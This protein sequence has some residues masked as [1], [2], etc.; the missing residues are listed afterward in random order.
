MA[1]PIYGQNKQ[2]DKFGQ[3]NL[4]NEY[5][6]NKLAYNSWNWNDLN[7]RLAADVT[8]A[9][10]RAGITLV[11]GDIC[12]CLVDGGTGASAITLPS[13][14]KGSLTVFRFSAQADGGQNIVFSCG[15]GDTFEAG[16]I[17]VGVT[18]LGD[19]LMVA[20]RPAYVETWTQTVAVGGGAIVTVAGAHNTLTIA[21]TATDN[22]TAI[23][24]E[25]AFFCN[26]DNKWRFGFLGSELGSGAINAT[27][28][29]STV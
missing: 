1:N 6:Q 7:L 22:Q 25:L 15:S 2:D 9:K 28:A 27:F 20:R 14:H 11:N 24:A 21:Q 8:D 4:S 26:E 12:E 10:A 19:G 23:G 17:C 3:V 13:A 16:T 18:N 29:T 5:L